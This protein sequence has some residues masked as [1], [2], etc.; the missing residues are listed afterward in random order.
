M[1]SPSR[2]GPAV[3]TALTGVYPLMLVGC[4][5]DFPE[6][7]NQGNHCAIRGV[8]DPQHLSELATI[9]PSGSRL[10]HLTT[11]RY[12]AELRCTCYFVRNKLR[13]ELST[14]RSRVFG[15]NTFPLVE[16]INFFISL[17]RTP[18]PRPAIQAITS[19]LGC[20]VG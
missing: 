16:R 4:A 5:S 20:P 9:Q 19:Y 18:K 15:V 10:T 8:D 14:R 6:P 7:P 11:S 17:R 1:P 3:T 13:P 2:E 12:D